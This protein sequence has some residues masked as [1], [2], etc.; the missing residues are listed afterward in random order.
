MLDFDLKLNTLLKLQLSYSI[1]GILFNIVSWGLLLSSGKALTPTDPKLGVWVMI[2]YA[3]FL[4][5]G[6]M[7]RILLFR[8]LMFLAV[9]VFGYS[10]VIK[11]M[12]TLSHSPEL[13]RTVGAGVLAIGINLF[14]V[15]LNG[16]AALGLF[17]AKK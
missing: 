9:L 14:G 5:A 17:K 2:L 12:L 4:L 11:H 13:Y 15:G 10:G 1:L 16:Y 3:L 8:I 6:K 7:K